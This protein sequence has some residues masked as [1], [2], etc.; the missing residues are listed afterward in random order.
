MDA[1]RDDGFTSAVPVFFESADEFFATV[2]NWARDLQFDQQADQRRRLGLWCEASGMVPQL[3]RVAAR[4]GV[5]VY[6]SGGFDSLTE[7]HRIG[8]ERSAEPITVLYLGDHDPSGVDCFSALDEDV[9]AFAPALC[10][11]T[12]A[13]EAIPAAVRAAKGHRSPRI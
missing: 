6:S 1:I 3:E 5:G 13:G 8:R 7:K 12:R 11:N 2:A 9:V 4:L 10:R